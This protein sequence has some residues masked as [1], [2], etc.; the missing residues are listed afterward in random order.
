MAGERLAVRNSGAT[1]VVE[2]CGDH[3]CEY[4]TGGT[5]VVVGPTGINFAAGMSGGEAFVWD[6]DG[7]LARRL[8]VAMAASDELDEQDEARLLALLKSHREATGSSRVARILGD[9]ATHRTEFLVVRARTEAS[10]P[11]QR[12]A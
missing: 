9:W 7:N 2:G 3:G 12:T 4:M 1:V 10:T 11:A 5:V 6:R 8:N